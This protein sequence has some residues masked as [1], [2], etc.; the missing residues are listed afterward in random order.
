METED[1][2]FEQVQV[3]GNRKR[4]RSKAKGR[5]GPSYNLED[6]D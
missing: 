4:I 6:V 2:E 3:G 5:M 1:G